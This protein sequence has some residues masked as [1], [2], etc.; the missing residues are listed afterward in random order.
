MGAIEEFFVRPILENTG[1]NP[2]NTITYGIIFILSV[3]F[4][5]NALRKKIDID[6]RFLIAILPFIFFGSSLRI[7]ED[8]GITH[9][10]FLMS[11]FI[12]LIVVFT[13]LVALW[14]SISLERIT[15]LRYYETMF[16]FGSLLAFP[17]LVLIPFKQLDSLFITLLMTFTWI[18]ILFSIKRILPAILSKENFAI[19]SFHLF[20][21]SSTFVGVSYFGYFEQHFL[22]SA[23]MGL[24]GNWT[25]FLLKLVVVLPVLLIIDRYEDDKK[26]AMFMK[27]CII[28]LGLGPGI[29]DTLRIMALS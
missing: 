10:V 7:W 27:M 20:D 22:P 29:R 9:S 21:A 16:I 8:L 5:F 17:T 12:W 25:F 23:V 15:K 13:A 1:Y 28:V 6:E 3:Y 11:P 14:V 24:F 19:I 4:L 2:V 26:F 18:L